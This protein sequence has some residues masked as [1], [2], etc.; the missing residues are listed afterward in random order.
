MGPAEFCK[1]AGI[2]SAAYIYAYIY[3]CTYIYLRVF[4]ECDYGTG[5]SKIHT[6]VWQVRGDVSLESKFF[7]AAGW[8]LRVSVV[9][10]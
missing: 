7:R 6:I 8:K 9:L 5:I 1:F 3:I 4:K 2:L 10:S